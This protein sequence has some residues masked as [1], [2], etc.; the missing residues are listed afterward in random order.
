MGTEP[1]KRLKALAVIRRFTQ[2]AVAEMRMLLVELRPVALID[3]PLR[4]LLQTLTSAIDAR[5]DTSVEARLDNSPRL[6]PDVQIGLYRIA[7][8]AV[9]NVIKHSGAQNVRITLDVAP[10]YLDGGAPSDWYGEVALKVADDGRG[11]DP[12]QAPNGRLGMVDMRERAAEIGAE[13]EITSQPGDGTQ[14]TVTWT[15]YSTLP[16]VTA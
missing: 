10:P 14:V 2:A 13:L 16:E 4:D 7:Q 3:S 1:G 9:N 6:P 8:E 12:S 15:G 11:F 5:D